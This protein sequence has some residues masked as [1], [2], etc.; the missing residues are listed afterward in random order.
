MTY[1]PKWKI[2]DRV[3]RL[4]FMDDGTWDR[5]GDKCLPES[6]LKHGTVVNNVVRGASRNCIEVLFDDG[7]KGKY[8][9]HG[10]ERE[11]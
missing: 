9:E 11:Q 8:L 5:L 2:G 6:P 1:Q 4:Q 7:T 3:T 10:V